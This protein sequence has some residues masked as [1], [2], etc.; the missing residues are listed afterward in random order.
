MKFELKNKILIHRTFRYRN[1]YINYNFLN[2]YDD[3]Y[4]LGLKYE[5]EDLKKQIPNLKI[6]DTKNFFEMAKVIK[7]SKF[8]LGNLSVAYPI[9]EALKIPRLLE[10]CPEFPVVQ[11][12]GGDGYDFY[13]QPQKMV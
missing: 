6:Y 9:A 4:F 3:I 1:K 8:F 13:Y 12:I 10:A 5:Y 11:P 2:D 7:S